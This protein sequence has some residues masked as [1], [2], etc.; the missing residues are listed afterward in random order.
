MDLEDSRVR[1]RA[2]AWLEEQ[3]L[4][5]GE[6]LDWNPLL[7]EGFEFQGR[8]IPLVSPQ[9]GIWKPRGMRWSLS[10]LT[11]WRAPY[12][13]AFEDEATLAYCHRGENPEHPDNRALREAMRHRVPLIYFHGIEQNR[14]HATW[15][16]FVVGEDYDRRRFFLR[17]EDA[18]LLPAA[19]AASGAFLVEEEDLRRRYGTRLLRARLHQQS[20]RT[21]VL[22]AYQSRCAICRLRRTELLEAAHIVPDREPGGEPVVRNGLAL[23]SLHHDAWDRLLLG[24]RPDAVVEVRQDVLDEEDGPMLE[25]GLQGIHRKRLLLPRREA[26]RPDPDRLEWR[27]ER[28]REAS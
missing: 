25:H 2:F 24:I 6:V 11:S 7:I 16:V 22:R 27:Y 3:T 17:T 13:D 20:F 23:C 8:R 5:H 14:Y 10:V 9:Q 18:R 19:A 4:L 12:D 1:Q 26:D 15:P 28:F 21:R